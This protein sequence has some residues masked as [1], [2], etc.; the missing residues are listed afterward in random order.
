MTEE[1]AS[2]RGFS[3]P[4]ES[5]VFATLHHLVSKIDA[6]SRVEELVE[7]AR[8]LDA[9]DT[10]LLV[11]CLS[12]A[13]DKE[14]APFKT[15][16]YV[17]RSLV[18]VASS[19]KLFAQNHTLS[20]E[21]VSAED[22]SGLPD[23][24]KISGDTS[25]C[26][27]IQ[28]TTKNQ[29]DE[30]YCQ[31]LVSWVHLS[32]PNILPLFYVAS[33]DG[34]NHPCLVSPCT[35][36]Q[37]ICE[38]ITANPDT[39]RIPLMSDII[40][41][42]SY[43]H[44][45]DIIHGGLNPGSVSVSDEGKAIIADLDTSELPPVRYSAPELLADED[46][47]PT[48]ATDVWALACLCYEISSGNV[49]FCQISREI[50]VS[51]AVVAGNKPIRP[52][53]GH[54]GGKEIT[55]AFWQIMLMSWEFE[56]TNRPE[57]LTVQQVFLASD[58]E[59]S[60]SKSYP[61]IQPEKLKTLSINLEQMKARLRDI[62]GSENSPSLHVP[63][64][65]RTSLSSF[66]PDTTKLK[67]TAAAVKRLDPNETQV[68]VDFLDLVLEDLTDYSEQRPAKTLLSDIMTSTNI[69]PRRYKISA[70]PYNP[71]PVLE[72]P[73]V[74]AYRG[75]GTNVRVNV[76]TE[77]QAV[78]VCSFKAYAFFAS[79]TLHP[80][81]ISCIGVF[82]EDAIG[83]PRPCVVTSFSDYAF[84]EDYASGIPQKE[85]IP[86]ISDVIEGM[87]YLDEKPGLI[88][89]YTSKEAVLV[90]GE[91]RAVLAAFGSSL[92]FTKAT[93][94]STRIL[95]FSTLI[96]DESYEQESIWKLGCVCYT[97]LSRREPY[98]QYTE[99]DQIRSAIS[100]GGLPRRPS[101][102][103]EDIDEIGDEAWDLITQCCRRS[104]SDRP[105]I[106]DIKKL[107]ATWGIEDNRP[108]VKASQDSTFQEMRSRANVDF[109]HV[110]T[111][112]GKIQVE[113]LKSPLSKLLANHIKDVTGAVEMLPTDDIRN[114]V[115]FLDMTLKDHLTLS[116]EQ[117]RTLALLS[118]ITS[119]T[120]VFPR[121]YKLK[122]I[123]YHSKP[124]AEGG[125]GT[126]HRGTDL[127]VCVKVMVQV[128]SKALTSWIKE[129]VLWAHMSHPNIL[130]FCGVMV[131]NH[132]S[133]Q[134]IC[135]VSP[136]M[137]NGNLCNY[138]A[139]LPQKSRLPLALDVAK[140]LRH[141]HESGIFHGDLKGE[142]VLI[143]NEGR[144]LITDFG[145]TQ[146]STATITTSTSLIPTT[147]RF[148][149]PEVLLSSGG[150]TRERDIW[151]FGCLCYQ[152][153]ICG[154]AVELRDLTVVP[155]RKVFSRLPP[156]Y[157]YAQAMQI[158]AALSRKELPKR[159]SSADSSESDNEWDD[160]L[161]DDWDEIDEET[162]SLITR[163]C[164]PEPEDRLSIFAIQEVIGDMKVW[165]DRPA[166]KAGLGDEISKLRLKPEIDMTRAGAL[167][168]RLQKTLSP[169]S[170]ETIDD[171]S[172]VF[173][174]YLG[175]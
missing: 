93:T 157:Q 169:S 61:V 89:R 6:D 57:C 76:V 166:A 20:T 117:N 95:R 43:M 123:Q 3:V 112:F 37:N 107:I 47:Q 160:D 108:P 164:A 46:V 161:D 59:G 16:P 73:H 53:H 67:A 32:H 121:R 77:A 44:Q 98:Y 143:S 90:S 158:Q 155:F 136:Y 152:V 137:K 14:A 173:N 122:A 13:M 104:P 124:M 127:D 114:F 118:K 25:R 10:Q 149:A 106:R 33:L 87:I 79:F 75:R 64:H 91:G 94:S 116:N 81:S 103:D 49:P 48:K 150:L 23:V 15:R 65:L 144:C 154:R 30:L 153:W 35:K 97:V 2:A 27:Q 8:S 29:P 163:C 156:Y 45:F 171:F 174:S 131:E 162:W 40:N 66:I 62:L 9:E 5:E 88:F 60:R 50:R 139:R 105:K 84:L 39:A 17:W 70:I 83:S 52:G 145:T 54:V 138:V 133:A 80:N 56:P 19:A 78:K 51:G 21:H 38:Y 151:S 147:L 146:I 18:K 58:P 119:S 168:D 126:V 24:Y 41:G 55:D 102:A 125:Y 140:G 167:L 12:L 74:K 63:E 109:H 141:L 7:K 34:H 165:D 26:V 100:Q 175:F 130:P 172:S 113:L 135:L 42:L 1:H 132:T 82:F 71:T 96:D 111:L 68:F 85:R 115:D 31:S 11:D 86:L 170:E 159:R 101:H 110:E 36:N 134:R 148:A 28:R 92:F 142:N 99:E 72:G 120:H 22:N 128:D 69:V 4:T 129:L